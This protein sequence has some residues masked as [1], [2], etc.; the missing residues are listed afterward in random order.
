MT[1]QLQKGFFWTFQ[2]SLCDALFVWILILNIQGNSD[3][4]L[5]LKISGKKKKIVKIEKIGKSM[6]KYGL[7][8]LDQSELQV[9]GPE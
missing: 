8:S 6:K 5:I 7:K 2:N 1:S 9:A 3:L 4:V